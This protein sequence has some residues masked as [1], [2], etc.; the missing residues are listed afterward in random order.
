[1]ARNHREEPLRRHIRAWRVDRVPD[2]AR[3]ARVA[4][5]GP[6]TFVSSRPLADLLDWAERVQADEGDT[7]RVTIRDPVGNVVY[8]WIAEWW[9]FPGAEDTMVEDDWKP[10]GWQGWSQNRRT[11]WRRDRQIDR[12]V[13]MCTDVQEQLAERDRTI[14]ALRREIEQRRRHSRS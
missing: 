7:A 12:L 2:A 3:T 4:G 14:E 10:D 8:D 1:V 5:D 6:E 13:E 11:I 9:K